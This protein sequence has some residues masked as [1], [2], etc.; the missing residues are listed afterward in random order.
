MDGNNEKQHQDHKNPEAY[1]RSCVYIITNIKGRWGTQARFRRG[2][3]Q[4]GTAGLYFSLFRSSLWMCKHT[5]SS[6]FPRMFFGL[7]RL[8]GYLSL[9]QLGHFT[10]K[11]RG[12]PG[13]VSSIHR[14]L[15]TTADKHDQSNQTTDRSFQVTRLPYKNKAFSIPLVYKIYW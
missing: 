1:R 10:R 13:D 8:T 3:C 14:A 4:N 6:S 7:I 2:E 11:H 5:I 9:G 15:Y 12:C